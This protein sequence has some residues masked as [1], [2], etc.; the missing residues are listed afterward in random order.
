MTDFLTKYIKI[1]RKDIYFGIFIILLAVFLNKIT[2]ALNGYLTIK[3]PLDSNAFYYKKN[4]DGKDVILFYDNG[5]LSKKIYYVIAKKGEGIKSG[6]CVIPTDYYNDRLTL[7]IS[8]GNVKCLIKYD[9]L[10]EKIKKQYLEKMKK[11]LEEY[12]ITDT[13]M[14]KNF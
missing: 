1:T 7:S 2:N 6:S 11:I 14:M 10:N 8:N 12:K 9:R 5:E 13:G 4:F 3:I